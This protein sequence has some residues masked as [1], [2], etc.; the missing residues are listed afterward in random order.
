M[1]NKIRVIDNLNI[2]ED[3][4]YGFIELKKMKYMKL[5]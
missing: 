2:S 3:N 1:M 5:I 4:R